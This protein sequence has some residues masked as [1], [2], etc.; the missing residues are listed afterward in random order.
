[1]IYQPLLWG[2]YN[3]KRKI[4]NKNLHE[5]E[6]N[7]VKKINRE[8]IAKNRRKN[9][10]TKLKTIANHKF[11]MIGGSVLFI[12]IVIAIFADQIKTYDPFKLDLASKFM[13]PNAQ[14][15]FGTDNF[16]RDI[17]SRIVLGTRVALKTGIVSTCIS[18]IIGTFFGLLAGYYGG[19]VDNIIMRFMDTIFSIPSLILAIT[20]ISIMGPSLVNVFVAIAIIF[21]PIFARLV[22]SRVLELKR[23]TY[24]EAE[25]AIGQSNAKTIFSHILPN[26]LN[27]VIV[28]ATA[29][30]AEAVVIE[31]ALSFLGM[32]APPPTPSWGSMLLEAKDYLLQ[33]P[34][35][36]IFP[37]LAISITVLGINLLGDGLRDILDPRLSRT[38][39]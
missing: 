21:I 10:I 22:R 32:G 27:V 30:F 13:L 23:E 1:S 33:H 20:F 17:F 11:I 14:H 4:T 3:V 31:A 5:M 38:I 2:W 19:W 36:A 28:Q 18:T 37:G 34:L 26:L 25:N 9:L 24:I 35:F 7:L 6:K 8:L 39:T 29:V 15:L 12:I 16:G